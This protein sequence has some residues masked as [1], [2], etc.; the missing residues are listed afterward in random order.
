SDLIDVWF[1]SG[2]MPYAQWHYPFEKPHLTSP[3]GR[4]STRP[5]YETARDSTYNLL[6]ELK[7]DKIDNFTQAESVLWEQLKGKKLEEFKFRRQHII[8]QS[9]AD[10]VCLERMLVIEVD[11]GYHNQLEVIE[12][13]KIRTEHLEELGYKVI[14]FT[15]EQV[16][17]DIENVLQSILEELKSRPSQKVLPL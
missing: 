15:N 10:F 3:K 5:K 4:N 17:G 1:D 2:A 14:R 16:I 11:G 6:K 12:A 8:D 7:K 13:D 9:I